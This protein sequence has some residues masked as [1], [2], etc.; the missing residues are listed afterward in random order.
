MM[1]E[2]AAAHLT[3]RNVISAKNQPLETGEQLACESPISPVITPFGLAQI[4]RVRSSSKI[5][6]QNKAF[7]KTLSGVVGRAAV[8]P[9]VPRVS[10]YAELAF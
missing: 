1:G 8:M 5:G 3:R 7:G 2:R 10:Y 6:G 9:L 4:A